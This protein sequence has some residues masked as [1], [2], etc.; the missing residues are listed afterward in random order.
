MLHF[1][2]PSD[3]GLAVGRVAALGAGVLLGFA[4]S[5]FAYRSYFGLKMHK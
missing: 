3:L 2:V 1:L 5:F 4:R